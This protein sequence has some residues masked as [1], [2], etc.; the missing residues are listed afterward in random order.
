V[1]LPT[2]VVHRDAK[3]LRQRY[4]Y[5]PG[6]DQLPGYAGGGLVGSS[7]DPTSGQKTYFLPFNS[8][9]NWGDAEAYVK[10]AKAVDRLG[11]SLEKLTKQSDDLTRAQQK[12]QSNYDSLT[13]TVSGN[14]TSGDLFHQTQAGSVFG[15]QYAAGSVGAVNATL[16]QQIQ[17]ANDTTTLE[18]Q[19]AG[20][21]LSGDALQALI[22]QG[23]VSS[24]RSFSNASDADLTQYQSL[25][26]QRA[27]AVGTASTTA[28]DVTG[29]SQQLAEANA[30]LA[31][32]QQAITHT[33]GQQ[34][35]AQKTATRD[36]KK[37]ANEQ[38]KATAKH[39][40][41]ALNKTAHQARR[42]HK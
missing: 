25:Y 31:A 41:T 5:L 22:E 26:D 33:Q 37:L 14:L 35:K 3:F 4:G 17:D 21:G 2:E 18:K 15:Q 42:H 11:K 13:S 19:L 28:A 34:A 27:S 24:L 16:T 23:G 38:A 40:A 8:K 7:T 32:I 6:M 20:R 12:A 36:R 29:L 10:A 39:T 30:Q 9:V 1:V